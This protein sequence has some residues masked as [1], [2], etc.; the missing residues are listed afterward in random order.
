MRTAIVYGAW[1]QNIGNAFFNLGGAHL[2]EKAGHEVSLI[3]DQPAYAT[4]RNEA[5]GNFD[6]AFD[7][8]GSID[9]DLVVLQGPL[10]TS[11]LANIWRP[12]L[13]RLKQ[14]GVNW[15][16]LSGS[17]RKF[18]DEELRVVEELFLEHP[19]LF[20]STRDDEAFKKI[21]SLC[22]NTR[23]GICSAWFLPKVYQPPR[24][25]KP[26]GADGYVSFCF[27]HFVEPTL[28]VALDAGVQIGEG[29]F[30]LSYP[31]LLSGWRV[32][33]RLMRISDTLPT[34]GSTRRRSEIAPSC[35]QSI[36]RTHTFRPRF[37]EARI[38]SP[39][40]SR[41]PTSRPTRIRS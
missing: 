25:A 19:P 3:Q 15:A 7:F 8:I 1:G 13:R 33:P 30:T 14:R 37:I 4:F 27:D 5:K 31:R 40:T 6:N 17:F 18:T 36:V 10:F 34:Y 39:G 22:E 12:T 21:E 28:N 35:G 41:T 9:V 38:A 32:P 20:V 23:P 11:N 29:H 24:L 26:E 16:I 2:L